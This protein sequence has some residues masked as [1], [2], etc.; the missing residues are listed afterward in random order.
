M[1]TPIGPWIEST[2][3][4]IG[5]III[6]ACL[7]QNNSTRYAVPFSGAIAAGGIA[8]IIATGVGFSFPALYFLDPKSFTS[9]LLYFL[10][11]LVL[12]AGLCGFTAAKLFSH[13]L[14]VTQ[15]LPFSIGTIVAETL[16]AFNRLKD[17][18][19]LMYGV[20]VTSVYEGLVHF[21]SLARALPVINALRW[22]M[23]QIPAF[24][25]RLDLLPIYVAI[26]F[27]SGSLIAVPFSVGI[28]IKLLGIS[29]VH[30]YFFSYLS[31]ENFLFAFLSG[32]VAYGALHSL[33]DIP[34]RLYKTMK[35]KNDISLVSF[36]ST[37]MQA[38]TYMIL[39]VAITVL[40]VG[41]WMYV[42]TSFF[43]SLFIVLGTFVC[44]YQL[45]IIAGKISLAP[46]GR[47]ATFIMIPALLVFGVTSKQAIMISTFV[48][49]AGGVAVDTLFGQ[50]MADEIGLSRKKL[51]LY[52]AIGLCV[53][54]ISIGFFLTLLHAKFG[55]G[56]S[57]LLVQRA[58]G[59]VLLLSV[60]QFDS[61]ALIVGIVVASILNYFS[62]NSLLVLGG[63]VMPLDGSLMLLSGALLSYLFKK[64]SYYY[65][66]WS[67]VFA[68]A[69]LLM[70]ISS[71]I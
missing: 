31:H 51:W 8:G 15:K 5:L 29:P 23:V 71:F 55:I 19:Q 20:V 14:L 32:L 70:I 47:F 12:I 42:G 46:L 52:Q 28:L 44:C 13:E 67:G 34:Y 22:K 65:P 35:K 45:L 66:W 38:Y 64:P 40:S 41:Y 26:G 49:V 1:A 6:R 4:L 36:I 33:F 10:G 58:R 50:R 39:T 30:T 7:L 43:A 69:S 62:I 54:V 68:T 25:L 2:L 61:Y 53:A 56:S 48:E 60:S 21:F 27:I 17:A 63:I 16:T 9:G 59:R 24:S 37:Y 11:G 57:E 3:A 18:Y